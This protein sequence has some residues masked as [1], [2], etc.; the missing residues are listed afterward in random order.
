MCGGALRGGGFGGKEG[1]GEGE[2]WDIKAIGGLET[3]S[4]KV[5]HI[6]ALKIV[7]QQ[8]RY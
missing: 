3:M 1:V 7:W 6:T 8:M 4:C 5:R 2:L